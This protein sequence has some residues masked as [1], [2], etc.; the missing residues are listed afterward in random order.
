MNQTIPDTV[1]AYLVAWASGLALVAA[2]FAQYVL[3]LH[4][5]QLCL[6]QRI[7]F[8][9]ALVLA[10]LALSPNA[11]GRR[12]TVL[13]GLAGLALMVNSGI[14]F[15]HVGVERHWWAA[16]CSG[17]TGDV[18]ANVQELAAALSGPAPGQPCDQPAW[19]W[20]GITMASLNVMYSAAIGS[21]VL[22]MLLPKPKAK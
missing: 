4:P 18:A 8:A 11:A 16:S 14:A 9:L 3:G 12:R 20:Q 22:G 1:P 19:Q 17:S 21:L 5:C 15:Y 6:I 13:I 10:V 7:P 2:F